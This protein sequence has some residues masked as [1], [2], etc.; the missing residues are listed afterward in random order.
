MERQLVRWGILLMLALIFG[1]MLFSMCDDWRD[2]DAQLRVCEKLSQ[3]IEAYRD[4]INRDFKRI[5]DE[6]Q[7]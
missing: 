7:N 6:T 2:R 4:C 1:P 5:K 3:S